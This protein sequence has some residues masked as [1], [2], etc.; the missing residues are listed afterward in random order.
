VGFIGYGIGVGITTIFGLNFLDSILAFRMAPSV[1][2]F[3]A[4]GV[5]LIISASALIGIRKVTGLDP[6]SVFRG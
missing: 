1:L 4:L 3:A 6:A 5:G 2:V